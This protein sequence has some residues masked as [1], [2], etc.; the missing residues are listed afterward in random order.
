VA[1]GALACL[2]GRTA[3][4]A[5]IADVDESRCRHTRRVEIVSVDPRDQSWEI[6]KPR[7]RVYF[8]DAATKSY[9]Y[10]VSQADNVAEVMAW[11]EAERG[12]RT[13]TLYA[14]AE[15]D[16]LGLVRLAGIDPT[17]AT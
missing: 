17:R 4:A 13:Y 7:Y 14:C 16:G 2:S 6:D 8:C 12:T 9:E 15:R 11:A 1:R 5:A 10:E 3:L